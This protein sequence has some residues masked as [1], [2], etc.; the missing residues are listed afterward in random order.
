MTEPVF[1]Q[2][3]PSEAPLFRSLADPGLVGRTDRAAQEELDHGRAF[4]ARRLPRRTG[5][6]QP[7]PTGNPLG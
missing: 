5:A 4:R 1:R 7:R 2:L 6:H 3:T